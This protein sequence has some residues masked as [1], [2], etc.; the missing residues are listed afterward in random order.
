[1]PEEQSLLSTA[2]RIAEQGEKIYAEKYRGACEANNPGQYIAVDVRTGKGYIREF[3]ELA[4]QDGRDDAPF[5]VFHLI[6][7]GSPGAF[8][9]S[10]RSHAGHHHRTLRRAG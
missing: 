2:D 1:M 6:R 7:I 3:P 4:L 10:H 5:G 9:T 8:K